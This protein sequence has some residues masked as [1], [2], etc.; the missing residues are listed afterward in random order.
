MESFCANAV[1]FTGEAINVSSGL[2]FNGYTENGVARWDLID[3]ADILKI[4]VSLLL[5]R[6][7]FAFYISMPRF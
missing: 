7:R 5:S 3:N 2:G 6:F 4:E 1:V